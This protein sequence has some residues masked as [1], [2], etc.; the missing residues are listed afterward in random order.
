[1]KGQQASFVLLLV[2]KPTVSSY[3][4]ADGA[5]PVLVH[6]DSGYWQ[7]ITMRVLATWISSAGAL[8]YGYPRVSKAT[9]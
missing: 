3:R 5:F 1:L 8:L 6:E 4:S 7:R 2:L 9:K